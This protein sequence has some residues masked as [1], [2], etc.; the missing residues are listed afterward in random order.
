[1]ATFDFEV[2]SVVYSPDGSD[3][4]AADRSGTLQVLD[5]DTGEVVATPE[6]VSGRTAL[7]Y[8]PDGRFLAGAGPGPLAH[9]WDMESHRIVRRLQGAAY[10]PR[11]VAF[12]NGGA[13]LRV[14]SGEGIDRGYVIDPL[15]LVELARDRVTRGLT[16]AE[17]QLHLRRPCAP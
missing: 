15:R 14:A 2:Y 13:E 9:L 16:D 6:R 3:L 17:C 1:V 5:A 10:P 11:G 12:V 7:V 4:A 8:S